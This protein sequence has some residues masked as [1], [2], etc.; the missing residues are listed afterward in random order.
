MITG[1]FYSATSWDGLCMIL[2]QKLNV[3]NL[4]MVISG[5]RQVFGKSYDI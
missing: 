5:T 3:W 1:V 4:C 2:G